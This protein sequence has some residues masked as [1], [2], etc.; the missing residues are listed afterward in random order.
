M[1]PFMKHTRRYK[2]L[3]IFL[4]I[5]A[6]ETKRANLRKKETGNLQ[7]VGDKGVQGRSKWKQDGR[8][9]KGTTHF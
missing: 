3:H 7:R 8:H 1:L 2:K 4:L 6:K 9:E 5:C